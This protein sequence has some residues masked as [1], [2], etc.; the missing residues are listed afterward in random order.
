M[1]TIAAVLCLLFTSIPL[2]AQSD[3]R[4]EYLNHVNSS[5]A[6]LYSQDNN[7]GMAM[8]C[9]ATAYK[10]I[11]KTDK[12]SAG[13]R[14][15]SASHC[16]AGDTD[17]E[18]KNGTKY[19][20][21]FDA[22]GSKDFI[23]ASVVAAGDRKKGDDFSIF[24]VASDK[25]IPVTPLGDES[26]LK[27]DDKVIDVAAPLGLGKQFFEGY[28]S[29]LLLDRP[30]LEADGVNWRSVMLVKIGGGPGSSGS[31]VV[32]DDQKAIIGFLVGSFNQGDIGMIIMPVSKFKAFEKAVDNGT[33]KKEKK[34]DENSG[35]EDK[36]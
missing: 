15:V 5:V 23:P 11:D 24:F 35:D 32:S 3:A 19:Y 25:V 33:Y 8:L 2:C 26:T 29:N 30:Q 9:T 7:G 22:T 31:A 14:F 4:Q 36:F 13:Y 16:V 17:D 12:Q 20:I 28:I 18:Q 1:K 6:L 10:K 21:S 34:S 27:V